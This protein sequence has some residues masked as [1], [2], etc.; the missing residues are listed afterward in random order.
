MTAGIMYV[1]PAI[2]AFGSLE[3]AMTSRA[4]KPRSTMMQA[5]DVATRV[6]AALARLC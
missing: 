3:G 6:P 5:R 4:T 1:C 2:G